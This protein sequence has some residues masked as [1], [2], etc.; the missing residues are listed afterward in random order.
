MFAL[1]F[2]VCR[3]SRAMA[4]RVPGRPLLKRLKRERL[5]ERRREKARP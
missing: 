3:S 5:D 2:E 1:A 4:L